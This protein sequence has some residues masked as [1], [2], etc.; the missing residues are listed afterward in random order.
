[1][2]AELDQKILKA[3]DDV[4]R[5]EKIKQHLIDLELLLEDRQLK[6]ARLN[7][8]LQ[9]EQADY[10]KVSSGGLHRAFSLMLGSL[11]ESIEKEHQEYLLAYMD[12][13]NC[14]EAIRQITDE[15]AL[16]ESILDGLFPAEKELEQLLERKAVAIPMYAPE[17]KEKM[18][19]IDHLIFAL[20]SKLREISEAIVAGLQAKKQL[21][22]IEED[23]KLVS[24][25]GSPAT[26]GSNI[27]KK[28]YID[29]AQTD[30]NKTDR[31]LQRFQ[32]ELKDIHKKFSLSYDSEIKQL[33]HFIDRYC[34]NL[35]VDWVFKKKINNTM[36][37]VT[38]TI[39]NVDLI[40]LTLHNEQDK[41]KQQIEEEKER[42]RTLLM[43]GGS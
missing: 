42:K 19:G 26:Y 27:E 32:K 22:Q 15:K 39:D 12:Y 29:R 23:L 31:L 25:W 9:K 40:L 6:L 28:K 38:Q 18:A 8:I 35:I 7:A 17:L 41:T 11:K 10:A 36:M 2:L 30:A 3:K 13:H 43:G 14:L 33:Y 21:I 24:N 37:G 5:K 16:L 34:N 1:M 20:H 4:Q